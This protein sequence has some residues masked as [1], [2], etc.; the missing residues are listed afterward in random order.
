MKPYNQNYQTVII[1]VYLPL[2]I[3]Y[4]TANRYIFELIILSLE[5]EK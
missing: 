2:A 3:I 1:C 4:Q 5:Y